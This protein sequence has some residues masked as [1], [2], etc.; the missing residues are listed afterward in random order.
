V[1]QGGGEQPRWRRDGK[2]LFYLS[3]DAKIT[4]VPVKTTG[5]FDPG[6][7]VPLF[8]TNLLET[9]ATSEHFVYDVDPNGQ[10]ILVNMLEK[11]TQAQPMTVVLNWGELLGK[12]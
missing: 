4:A 8:Q 5:G 1:S 10:R 11:G 3:G 9:L 12:K 7:P 2:E 6:T